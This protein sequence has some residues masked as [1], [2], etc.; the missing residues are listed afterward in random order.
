MA[1]IEHILTNQTASLS[2]VLSQNLGLSPKQTENL[3][4][5]GAI[6]GNKERLKCSQNQQIDP[7]I[8]SGTYLRVHVEPKRFPL[9]L[10]TLRGRIVAETDDFL[11]AN[12]PGGLP[13]HPT[14]DNIQE[15][16]LTGLQ[17]ILDRQIFIT[18][19]LDVG[20][21][22]LLLLAKTQAEQSRINILFQ[23]SQVK[24]IYRATVH[25]VNLPL[26]EV[27]HYMK[28]SDRSP[29]EVQPF[30]AQGQISGW[31]LCKLRILDQEE[32]FANHSEVVIELLTGRTHQIRA[33]FGQM[34]FPI[35]G[36][37]MY[38]SPVV[39]GDGREWALQCAKLQF[40]DAAGL[41]KSYSV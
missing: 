34:G 24:K 28:P 18:H 17:N 23:N 3:L 15:N 20:T 38:G 22:G 2:S 41:L 8:E 40:P 32:V 1:R 7:L 5:L 4:W 12:K 25:G 36:D 35:L 21:S 39:L 29:R 9:D 10:E 6:Y 33:Q 31:Q 37:Q 16:L 30:T 19:R 14:L 11:V 13:V 27:T 26:G